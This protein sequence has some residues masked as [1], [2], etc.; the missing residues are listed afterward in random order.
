MYVR[1]T[2]RV[3]GVAEQCVVKPDVLA[4]KR[5]AKVARDLKVRNRMMLRSGVG[6]SASA[7]G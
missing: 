3:L 4:D 5:L 6:P 1:L 7:D 2:P